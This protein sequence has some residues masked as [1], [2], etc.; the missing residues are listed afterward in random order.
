MANILLVEDTP[1]L[2]LFEAMLLEASGHRVLRCSGGPTPFAACPLMRVGSCAVADAADLIV[3]SCG[4]VRSLPHRTYRGEHLLRRYR[5]HPTY[6]SLPMLLI[7][8]KEP[9]GLEGT[10]RIETIEK[11]SHPRRV[12]AAVERLL[13]RRSSELTTLRR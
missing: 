13:G 9:A 7:A 3:F 8:P 10:G 5:S 1:D 12:L 2:G 11:F 6:G 4:M